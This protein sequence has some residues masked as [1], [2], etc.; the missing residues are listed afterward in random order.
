MDSIGP[1]LLHNRIDMVGNKLY[2]SFD[3]TVKYILI[4]TFNQINDFYDDDLFQDDDVLVHLFVDG[5]CS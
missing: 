5:H 2:I 4:L 3:I 1:F